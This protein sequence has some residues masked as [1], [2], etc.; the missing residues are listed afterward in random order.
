[1]ID[2][3]LLITEDRLYRTSCV[4]SLVSAQL[5]VTPYAY[6]SVSVLQ[7]PSFSI[8][9]SVSVIL[10]LLSCV[11]YPVSVGCATKSYPT[12]LD[13]PYD[14]FEGNPDKETQQTKIKEYSG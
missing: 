5:S 8:C 4:C 7:C 10:C 3:Q 2:V 14:V 9:S 6:P 11:C 1:M 13:V 12:N